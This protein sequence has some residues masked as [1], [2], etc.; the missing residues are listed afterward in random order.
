MR[1]LGISSDVAVRLMNSKA[2]WY[3]SIIYIN[4]KLSKPNQG[5][6]RGVGSGG[7]VGWN[8]GG[9]GVIPLLQFTKRRRLRNVP[10]YS[11]KWE[12]KYYNNFK[13]LGKIISIGLLLETPIGL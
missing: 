12:K 13:I 6:E 5:K 2:R 4:L 10:V 8:K 1:R 9:W 3:F 11:N 7:E